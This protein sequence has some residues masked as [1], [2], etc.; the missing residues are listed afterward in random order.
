MAQY[1]DGF[2]VPVLKKKLEAYR[3]MAKRAAKLWVKC[4]ALE[5][6]GR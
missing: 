5:V 3:K 1:V 2:V 4:G 6:R